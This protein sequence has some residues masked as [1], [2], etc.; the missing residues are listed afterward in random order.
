MR[1]R[2]DTALARTSIWAGLAGVPAYAATI[3]T[4][5][6][7]RTWVR[8][9]SSGFVAVFRSLAV[10]ALPSRTIFSRRGVFPSTQNQAFRI[11]PMNA[12]VLPRARL[13]CHCSGP[14]LRRPAI[15]LIICALPGRPGQPW[16]PS[17]IRR[18]TEATA[19]HDCACLRPPPASASAPGR[20]GTSRIAR[21]SATASIATPFRL[22]VRAAA[23]P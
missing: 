10:Q 2:P 19:H 20:A 12:S 8:D 14:A 3:E 22:A 21:C 4:V 6:I 18:A 5:P 23:R 13:V 17:A 15:W 1:V 16:A 11:A 7:C 9:P